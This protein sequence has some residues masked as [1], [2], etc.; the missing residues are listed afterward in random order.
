M[1]QKILEVI[2]NIKE[3]EKEI[4]ENR[5][6]EDL[7]IV[8]Q[9]RIIVAP[10]IMIHLVIY[11]LHFAL[12]KD[13]CEIKFF[14]K[15]DY[16]I[17]TTKT[18]KILLLHVTSHDFSEELS[19]MENVTRIT[20]LLCQYGPFGHIRDHLGIFNVFYEPVIEEIMEDAAHK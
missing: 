15:K 14:K 18:Q 2:K 6:P 11:L 19:H 12:G 8:L 3:S 7:E 17:I 9:E 20:Y 5:N 1:I 4:L 10:E 13:A 16:F